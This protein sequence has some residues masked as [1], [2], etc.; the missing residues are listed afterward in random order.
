MMGDAGKIYAEALFELCRDDGSIDKVYGVLNEY[1]SV[2]HEYPQ[3]Q[4]LLSV[5]TIALSEKLNVIEKIFEND[6]LAYNFL[7]VITE[8]NRTAIFDSIADEFSVRYNM[9]NNISEFTVT[10]S[11]P[12]SDEM[13]SKLIAK[14][15]QKSCKKVK[16][17][18][19]VVPEILGG[20]IIN[21][22]NTQ[23]DSSVKGKI[24]SISRQLKN[25]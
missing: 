23:V 13:R 22:G 5:P 3:L 12:M 11:V 14:L 21:Y 19:K 6:S 17:I 10:T 9:Y 8:K 4:K 25:I 18:E 7:C 16:L 24:E 2:F 1:R 20:I 15:E